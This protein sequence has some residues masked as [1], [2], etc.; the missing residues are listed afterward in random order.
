LYTGDSLRIS[1]D[2]QSWRARL[3]S[4]DLS[5]NG[6]HIIGDLVLYAP[7]VLRLGGAYFFV[8]DVPDPGAQIVSAVLL[9]KRHAE[10]ACERPGS[11]KLPPR[12]AWEDE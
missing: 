2:A 12:L 8:D 9:A 7:L 11:T 4:G 6:L 1:F 5:A 3:L 10:S